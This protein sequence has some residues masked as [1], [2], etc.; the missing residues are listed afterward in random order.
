MF[1]SID[2][3]C[4]PATLDAAID[5]TVRYPTKQLGQCFTNYLG[6]MMPTAIVSVFLGM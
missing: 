2:V 4:V 3:L 5:A 6:W 1:Q